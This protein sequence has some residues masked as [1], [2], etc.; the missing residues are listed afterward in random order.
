MDLSVII[1]NWKSLSRSE[2]RKLTR[3]M[4]NV[5]IVYPYA[6][7]AGIKLE[8]YKDTLLQAPDDR[9]RKKI[10]K[11]VEQKRWECLGSCVRDVN[12]RSFA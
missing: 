1:I 8:E 3:L 6:R 5:K 11:Q 9:A 4:K 12:D 2:E 7:L 10:M